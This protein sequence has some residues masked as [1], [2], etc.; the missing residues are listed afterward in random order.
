MNTYAWSVRLQPEVK[1]TTLVALKT[2]KSKY[3]DNYQNMS[4]LKGY[5]ESSRNLRWFWLNAALKVHIAI[6]QIEQAIPVSLK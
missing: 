4:T 1:I 6:R 3:L 2:A 5:E